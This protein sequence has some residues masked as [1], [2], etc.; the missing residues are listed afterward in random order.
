MDET[1]ILDGQC[2]WCEAATDEKDKFMRHTVH[3]SDYMTTPFIK[4]IAL[5]AIDFPEQQ[6]FVIEQIAE[7]PESQVEKMWRDKAKELM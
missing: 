3:K 5:M 4:R 6:D 2:D 7:A 1:H